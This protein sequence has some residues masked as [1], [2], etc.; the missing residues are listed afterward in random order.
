MNHIERPPGGQAV[1]LVSEE[2]DELVLQRMA[3]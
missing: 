1:R 3:P 2:G